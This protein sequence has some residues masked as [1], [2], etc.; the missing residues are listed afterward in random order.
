MAPP[1][2][3]MAFDFDPD[4]EVE[5]PR[6]RYWKPACFQTASYVL[7]GDQFIWVDPGTSAGPMACKYVKSTVTPS[8]AAHGVTH[9]YLSKSGRFPKLFFRPPKLIAVDFMVEAGEDGPTVKF[10]NKDCACIR[11]ISVKKAVTTA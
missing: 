4:T 6:A 1:Q 2:L 9:L 10:K 11:G 5:I 7:G 3:E 8:L